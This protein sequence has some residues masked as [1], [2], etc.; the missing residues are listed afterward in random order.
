M[1]GALGRQLIA[2]F[3]GCRPEALSDKH[4]TIEIARK[5]AKALKAEV[6]AEAA[7]FFEPTGLTVLLLLSKSHIAVHTWPEHSYAA[8]DIFYCSEEEDP[9]QAYWLFK[10]FFRPKRRSV[11]IVPRGVMEGRG[12]RHSLMQQTSAHLRH[13]S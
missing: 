1:K 8:L 10:Q 11:I 9:W 3:W 6:K 7:H 12:P 5:A 4:G 13:L 2:E